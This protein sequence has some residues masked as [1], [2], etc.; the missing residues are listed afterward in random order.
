MCRYNEDEFP[1]IN[2]FISKTDQLKMAGILPEVQLSNMLYKP[3]L[4]EFR[5]IHSGNTIML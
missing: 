1:Y 2:V 5:N 4:A 3:L